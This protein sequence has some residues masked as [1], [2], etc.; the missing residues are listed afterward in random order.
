MATYNIKVIDNF[1]EKEEFDLIKDRIISNKFPVYYSPHVSLKHEEEHPKHLN[2]FHYLYWKHTPQSTVFSTVYDNLISKFDVKA[3]I[4]CKVNCYP[5]TDEHIRHNFHTD[6]DYSHSA[7]IFSLNTCNGWT[8]FEDGTR[9]ESVA[10]RALIFDAS[11]LH[12]SVTCTDQKCR[13]NIIFN[14]L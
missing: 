6:V 12:A 1:L 7:V 9:V 10:N 4:R 11:K 3:L 2:F 13:W 5:R 14:Y 8:E